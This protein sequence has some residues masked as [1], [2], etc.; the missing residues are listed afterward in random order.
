MQDRTARFAGKKEGPSI[1]A[2]ESVCTQCSGSALANC[3]GDAAIYSSDQTSQKKR[4]R[5]I[6]RLFVVL[7]NRVNNN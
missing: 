1:K 3:A 2:S 7:M 5:S 4:A 6:D